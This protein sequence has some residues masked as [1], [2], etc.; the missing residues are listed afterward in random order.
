MDFTS[1]SRF[2]HPS[3]Y[4][5]NFATMNNQQHPQTKEIQT[6][7]TYERKGRLVNHL[8]ADGLVIEMK[9]VLDLCSSQENRPEL[10]FR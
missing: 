5:Q 4:Q 3:S 8:L 1:D 9:I 7:L 6:A 2:S 10:L